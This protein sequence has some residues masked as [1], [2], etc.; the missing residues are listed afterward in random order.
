MAKH[1]PCERIA[2]ERASEMG[3]K[4]GV[5]TYFDSRPG[6]L[7][8]FIE[9]VEGG[10]VFFHHNNN[11]NYSEPDRLA[12]KG[13][14]VEFISADDPKGPK[15]KEWNFDP[16]ISYADLCHRSLGT[17]SQAGA[18]YVSGLDP[19]PNLSEGIRIQG[20]V[21]MYHTLRIH[22]DDVERFV[23]RVKKWERANL[24]YHQ[25]VL[26]YVNEGERSYFFSSR[27]QQP[28]VPWGFAPKTFRLPM[29]VKIRKDLP[30]GIITRRDE[31]ARVYLGGMREIPNP[32]PE[33]Q[34]GETEQMPIPAI[35]A[36]DGGRRSDPAREVE[37]AKPI[38]K[39]REAE[40]LLAD[41]SRYALSDHA[42]GD[43]EVTWMKDG[44]LVASGY[45]GRTS[46]VTLEET[47]DRDATS[48]ADEAAMRLRYC[49]KLAR[50]ERNDVQD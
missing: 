22:R 48:F 32:N 7:F 21:G 25:K 27:W 34:P 8:G 9:P 45:F 10:K 13:D 46:S 16:Y 43:S 36:A 14:R 11:A 17:T 49:G 31:L 28:D 38:F 35:V 37:G 2:S 50:H 29:V 18:Y 4:Q 26:V 12:K 20:D 30:D 24:H 15:A 39:L 6:K 23:S 41:S 44:K 47:A 33:C 40:A 5:V 42:F 19:Y 3:H 1:I